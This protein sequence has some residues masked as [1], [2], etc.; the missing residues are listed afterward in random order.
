[1]DLHVVLRHVRAGQTDRQ[2]ARELGMARLTVQRYRQWAQQQGFLAGALPS[3]EVLQQRREETLPRVQP[4][5]NH[6][7]VEPYRP[8]VEKLVA[9]EVEIAAIWARLKERGF[10]GSYGA[11][12]RF[13][14]QLA[15]LAVDA[16][17]RVERPP[18]EEAQVDFGY[19]G[20]LQDVASGQ[21]RRSWAFVMTLSW[22]RHQYV[23]FVFD[24]QVKTWLCCHRNAF[25]FFQGVPQRLV[26]D[27][28]KAAILRA[29]LEEPE[30]QH[31]YRH[32]AEHY[33]FLI[34]PCRPRTPEHKEYVSYYTSL[35]L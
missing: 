11:V 7:S 20:R 26:I 32:C 10:G 30:V 2:V 15:P 21:W 33:G 27:N 4:P 25:D 16:T 1:M 8:L 22:S 29:C 9:A 24:Q 5:Q 34:A 13:V 14:R 3:L 6:S 28:L 17:V 23:E 31:S 18:G 12:Y 35:G 19:A